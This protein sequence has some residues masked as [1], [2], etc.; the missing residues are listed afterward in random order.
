MTPIIEPIDKELL[1]AELTPDK[2][3]RDTNKANNEIYIVN[4]HNAPN[5][6]REIGRLREETFREAGGGSGLDCDID[7]YD[8]MEVPY[9]QLIVWDAEA[10]SIIGGYRFILGRDIKLDKNNQP[11][12]ATAEM[13]HFSEKFVKE[14]LPYTVELGRSFISPPYQRVQAGVKALFALDNL[15]DGLAVVMIKNPDMKYF[16]GKVTMYPEF[17]REA[18]DIIQ[19]FLCKHFGDKEGLVRPMEP[20]VI[21]RDKAEMDAILYE[22]T[23]KDDY[24]LLNAEVR[25]LGENI[26]PL[27]N[28]YMNLSP[29]MKMFGGGINYNFNNAEESCI[30]ITFE[31]LYEEKKARHVDSFRNETK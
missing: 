3:V 16:F 30:F 10:E 27:V 13:F 26:P 25:R 15:F 19:H 24:K 6:M 7:F 2:K 18:R 23:F 12:L 29:S 8:T 4:H 17:N 5:V 1:K 11:I 20:L 22:K 31:D 14:Y 28:S 9:S 21:E